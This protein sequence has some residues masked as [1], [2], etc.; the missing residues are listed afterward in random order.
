MS[1]EDE[2]NKS[3]FD[4]EMVFKPDDYLYFYE[5]AY[6]TEEKTKREI[7]FLIDELC[8]RRYEKNLLQY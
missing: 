2:R 3:I 1:T 7:E 4:F 5:G 8:E 6:I